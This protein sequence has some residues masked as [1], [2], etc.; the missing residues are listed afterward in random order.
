M[1][2]TLLFT[3]L[4]LSGCCV[5]KL[6]PERHEIKD[7]VRV[8]YKE[9]LRDTIVR[10]P[11]PVE[12]IK[13]VTKDTVS[14]LETSVAKSSA[15]VSDGLL[16]H[17]LENKADSLPYRIIYKDVYHY[18]DSIRVEKQE[19][20]YSVPAELTKWQNFRLVLGNI[21]L[22]IF[23]GLVMVGLFFLLRKLKVL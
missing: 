18:R 23:G 17:T 1:R 12:V 19:I 11:M 22:F 15:V 7:S 21:A 4:I 6:P 14:N 5:K 8:E 10:I 3:L 2:T 16:Y 13:N 20:P 9:I